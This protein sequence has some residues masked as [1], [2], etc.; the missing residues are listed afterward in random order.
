[1][2]R[3]VV[4]EAV[5]AFAAFLVGVAAAVLWR[6][7]RSLVPSPRPAQRAL[8]PV[9]AGGPTQRL[10]QLSDPITNVAES[11]AHPRDLLENASFREAVAIF[12]SDQLSLKLVT[13]YV[14]GAN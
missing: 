2:Q 10:Q 8:S 4:L 11:S 12:E 13:D 9:N 3:I 1:M 5:V 6:R 14:G 7:V